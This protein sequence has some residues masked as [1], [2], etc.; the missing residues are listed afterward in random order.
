MSLPYF[1][2][3]PSDFEAKTSHLTLEEDGAY[4][5]LLRLCWMTPGCSLPDDPAWIARR[6]RVDLD[7]FNRVIA[8]LLDEFFH[9][10]HGRIDSPK[11]TRIFRETD[12]KHTRR[13]SAGKKGG[14]PAKALETNDTDQSNAKAMPKQP[15]PEPE[16]DK[17]KKER[18]PDGVPKKADLVLVRE[19]LM[20]VL[21]ATTAEAFIAHRNK[22][23][24]PMT[25]YA[26]RLI[27]RKLVGSANPV[28]CVELSIIKGWQDVF[29]DKG[30]P[31][32]A[33]QT[34]FWTGPRL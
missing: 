14:R 18:T 10:S 4:N 3:Y 17:E 33:G 5:R 23:K 30:V 20:T 2:L 26:A 16:L 15:E 11:L 22:L 21:D 6:M 1:P 34:D 7:T 25:P 28:A 8:P 29:P 32:V 9:R 12:E 24:K 13:V 27:A 31:A 19:A